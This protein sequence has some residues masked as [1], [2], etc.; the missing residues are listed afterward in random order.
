MTALPIASTG[1]GLVDAQ[2]TPMS[3]RLGCQRAS[4]NG[5]T[6]PLFVLEPAR[7]EETGSARHA[8]IASRP[9]AY[10]GFWKSGRMVSR[11]RS[12]VL[13]LECARRRPAARPRVVER[14]KHPRQSVP[15]QPIRLS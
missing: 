15:K 6:Y 10:K 14:R 9:S 13:E 12:L 8:E 4:L 3:V 11:Y 1:I 5:L 7:A 2:S